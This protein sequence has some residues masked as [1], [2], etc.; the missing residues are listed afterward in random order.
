MAFDGCPSMSSSS[1]SSS[2]P[3]DEE[4]LLDEKLIVPTA[5]TLGCAGGAGV[6][7]D[8]GSIVEYGGGRLE[9]LGVS[10]LC[11]EALKEEM[12]IGLLILPP[13]ETG[14]GGGSCWGWGWV[15]WRASSSLKNL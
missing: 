3:G 8:P 5:G 9:L 13:T 14:G 7:V 1:S 11:G 4:E 6:A 15:P 10:I 12:G 2:E